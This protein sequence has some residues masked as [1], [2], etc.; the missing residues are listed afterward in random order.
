MLSADITIIIQKLTNIFL[1]W[2]YFIDKKLNGI[3]ADCIFLHK[4]YGVLI[5]NICDEENFDKKYNCICHIRDC[6]YLTEGQKNFVYFILLTKS[7]ISAKKENIENNSNFLICNYEDFINKIKSTSF[8]N[9]FDSSI[10]EEVYNYVYSL[11]KWVPSEEL[12]YLNLT[13][14]QKDVIETRTVSGRRRVKGAAGSGKTLV[15]SL[16]AARLI[17]EGK[18]VLFVAYNITMPIY[19]QHMVN[20]LLNYPQYFGMNKSFSVSNLAVQNF[21]FIHFHGLLRLLRSQSSKS[22]I[23]E[24]S[25]LSDSLPDLLSH[26]ILNKP[27]QFRDF[28]FDAIIVDEGQDFCVPWIYMLTLLLKNNGEFLF[29]S[30][31]TQDIYKR[32]DTQTLSAMKGCGFSGIWKRL[33]YSYR[34]PASVTRLSSEFAHQFI[35]PFCQGKELNF[36][37]PDLSSQYSL[38]ECKIKWIQNFSSVPSSHEIRELIK[39]HILNEVHNLLKIEKL[40]F[41]DICLICNSKK[42]GQII[43]DYLN[44]NNIYTDST[45][46]DDIQKNRAEK[47][48]FGSDPNVLKCTT[49]NSYKGLESK[50]IILVNVYDNEKANVDLIEH[51]KFYVGL[52][53]VKES[54]DSSCYLI[55]INEVG[56]YNLFISTAINNIGGELLSLD[57]S[58]KLKCISVYYHKPTS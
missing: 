22:S 1:D 14:A 48:S 25:L 52:T 31:D 36:P 10:S 34:M 3:T 11:I 5:F 7:N 32:T 15:A 54:L 13:T 50:A 4:T 20:R 17:A 6:L 19:I 9:I 16:R 57:S 37:E 33:E 49:V 40:A 27:E 21:I 29:I 28:K 39:I 56:C 55:V 38:F 47:L 42:F 43:V 8:V 18:K 12:I 23:R 2:E 41:D 51:M 30:D 44:S 35:Y 26:E 46:S 45:F 24:Q 53:R 58:N